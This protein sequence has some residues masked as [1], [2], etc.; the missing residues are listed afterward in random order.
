MHFIALAPNE[1]LHP[2]IYSEVG[3]YLIPTGNS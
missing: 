1:F 3:F 2:I